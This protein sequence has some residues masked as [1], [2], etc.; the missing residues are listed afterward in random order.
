MLEGT[1]LITGT[2]NRQLALDIADHLG[3]P[4]TKVDVD[5]F[6]DGEIQV[7]IQEH[8]RGETCFVIQP[9]CRPVNDNLMEL[10]VIIDALKRADVARIIAVIPYYGYSRQDRRPEDRRTPIS[11]KVVARIIENAGAD[12]V[13]TIDIHSEQQ[14]GFFESARMVNLSASPI[15]V[16]DIWRK[17]GADDITIVSPDIGGTT[18]ARAIAKK[19]DTET[20]GSADESH[21]S[22]A[23]IDKRRPAPNVSEVMHI[24]GDVEGKTCVIVDDMAD[25][26]GT[27]CKGAMALKKHGATKVV[28]YCTHAVLS[29]PAYDNLLTSVLDEIV[30]TDTIPLEKSEAWKLEGET[31]LRVIS[32]AGL[33]S[34]AISR[35]KQYD[36]ISMMYI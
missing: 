15:I 6:S 20:T 35:L 24:I 31:K 8:V 4:L 30:V 2:A 22:L 1:R 23:I 17:Y 18:R 16:S 36:S 13:V 11:A 3:T 12:M 34:Q 10:V 26:A 9:T 27:L 28:A 21:I 32:V 29:G 14:Q 19:L 5:R 33:L 7:E 25:T